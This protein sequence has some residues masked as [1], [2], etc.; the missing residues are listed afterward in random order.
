MRNTLGLIVFFIGIGLWIIS[1]IEAV[2]LNS[3]CVATH[4][5]SLI[6]D[7]RIINKLSAIEGSIWIMGSFYLL[8]GSSVSKKSD[9]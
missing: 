9:G 6:S 7:V 3:A 1:S 4:T 8:Y 5:C 2:I